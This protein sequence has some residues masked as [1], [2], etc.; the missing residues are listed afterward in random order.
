MSEQLQI[1]T[2]EEIPLTK[3]MA[4]RD[5]QKEGFG[6]GDVVCCIN[7][8]GT[9]YRILEL[10]GTEAVIGISEEEAA[11]SARLFPTDEVVPDEKTVSINNLYKVSNYL[12]RESLNSKPIKI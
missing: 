9:A 4:R 6:V 12:K 10:R 1:S 2:G 11:E 5:S 3:E 8:D 7:G